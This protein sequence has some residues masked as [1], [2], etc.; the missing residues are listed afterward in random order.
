MVENYRMEYS[1][2]F[3][4]YGDGTVKIRSVP[5]K[6]MKMM[7]SSITTKTQASKLS[8]NPHH[9][10]LREFSK[11]QI[12]DILTAFG[13][14]NLNFTFNQ[15]FLACAGAEL[16]EQPINLTDEG[17]FIMPKHY[18]TCKNMSFQK[19]GKTVA[20]LSFPGSGNSWV[21]QLIETT[22]GIYTGTYRGCDDSYIFNGMI[23]E[24]VYTDNV[25]AVKVHYVP[26][27][28][29]LSWLQK[30]DR[31]YVVRNPFDAILSEWNRRNSAQHLTAHVSTYAAFGKYCNLFVS[32]V[33]ILPHHVWDAHTLPYAYRAKNAL[34]MYGSPNMHIGVTKF[35]I[36]I[37]VVNSAPSLQHQLLRY[38][39]IKADQ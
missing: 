1:R 4:S 3:E 25:I 19:T 22:T 24:G 23:G 6:F 30:H 11:S 32:A 5:K 21:R 38:S 17:K 29:K 35:Q 26:G 27:S 16:V 33:H 34:T 36:N 28:R 31:I 12:D 13:V 2:S 39:I 14:P 37:S 9:E 10:I 18:Q 20:L 7:Q 8:Y 15:Q